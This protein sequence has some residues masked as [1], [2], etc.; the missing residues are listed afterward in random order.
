MGGLAGLAGVL[1]G[2]EGPVCRRK[3]V[4]RIKEG[5]E[6][7][8]IPYCGAA[9]RS[10]AGTGCARTARAA[11]DLPAHPRPPT[12][13]RATSCGRLYPSIKS[14]AGEPG[15]LESY[16]AIKL[17]APRVRCWAGC[18]V[19]GGTAI[20]GAA[21]ESP[22]A[23]TAGRGKGGDRPTGGRPWPPADHRSQGQKLTLAARERA[24][25]AQVHI[26]H[27]CGWPRSASCHCFS[28]IRGTLKPVA[29]V[30]PDPARRLGFSRIQPDL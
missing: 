26:T 13:W 3:D 17:A 9:S 16:P 5:Y 19:L 25:R 29:A 20:C 10:A 8:K 7:D 6:K 1:A 18:S 28:D 21:Q 24:P 22:T 2:R 12:P 30:Y 27:P 23:G 4:G 14:K 11:P 15:R